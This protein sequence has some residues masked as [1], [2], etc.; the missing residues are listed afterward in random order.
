VDLNSYSYSVARAY[1][2]RLEKSDFETPALLAALSAEAGLDPHSF[3]ERYERVV[4]PSRRGPE[5]HSA[6]S[7]T[8]LAHGVGAA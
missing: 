5:T 3:R 6:P 8:V 7:E 1:M 2:I 4:G